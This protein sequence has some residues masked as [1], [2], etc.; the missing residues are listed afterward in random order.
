MTTKPNRR[1][2]RL[3]AFVVLL[4]SV[5]VATSWRVATRARHERFEARHGLVVEAVATSTAVAVGGARVDGVR[6]TTDTALVVELRVLRHDDG[7]DRP[8]PAVLLLG[9]HRTGRDAVDLVGDPGGLVIVA[10]DYPYAG[11]ERIRGLRAGIGALP[12]VREALLDTP[13]AVSVALDWLETQPW[14]DGRHVELAGVSLGVPFAAAAGARDPRFRRVWLIHGAADNR[15]WLANN[16][17]SRIGWGPVRRLA[18]GFLLGLAHGATLDTEHSAARIGPRELVIVQARDDATVPS[19]SAAR[20]TAAATG[21]VE[22]I[23]T[24]GG[25]VHPRKPETV[26]RLVALVRDAVTLADRAP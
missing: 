16:L 2:L 11:P 18:A 10:L 17:E 24:E 20:F 15:A 6:L 26:R 8:R 4:A 7:T 9:G 14:V 13:V 25:H 12:L 5:A 19:D 3:A 22:T 23:W 21:P 1:R